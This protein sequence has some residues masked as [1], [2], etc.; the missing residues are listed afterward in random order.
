MTALAGH[1]TKEFAETV[2]KAVEEQFDM[3]GYVQAHEALAA[4]NEVQ[5]YDSGDE[6]L[7]DD[8][9]ADEKLVIPSAIRSAVFRMHV[10]TGHRSPARLARALLI[11]GAPKE[12]VIAA[13]T[14]KCSICDERKVPKT[15]R[16]ASLPTPQQVGKQLHIDLLVI[17]DAM[18]KGYI[19]AHVTDAV[20]RFQFAALLSD[21]SSK[22]VIHF[23]KVHVFSVL[24]VP[25]VMIADQGREFVS[26][27]FADFADLNNIYVK[28]IGVQAPWQ[29]GVA[30][31]S[32]GTLKALA[33]A[34]V[35]QHVVLDE[36]GMREAVA[37]AVAAYNSDINEDGTSP[38]QAV[39]GRQCLPPGD[40]LSSLSTRLAEH[41]LI[42]SNPSLARQVAMRETA[43]LSMVKLHYSK[44]LRRAALARARRVDV[45]AE[46]VPGD[47]VYFWRKIKVNSRKDKGDP[48]AAVG[49]RRGVE[50][51]RWHGPGLAVAIEGPNVFISYRGTLTKCAL[52]MTR[53][54]SSLEHLAAED[55]QEAIKELIV[56]SANP[57]D[58]EDLQPGAA[59]D[60]DGGEPGDFPP[61]DGPDVVGGVDAPMAAPVVPVSP[62]EIV[63]ALHPSS[64]LT[65][66]APSTL[67]SRQ[68]SVQSVVENRAAPG[69]PVGHLLSRVP[70]TGVIGSRGY[71][72]SLTR[73][74][75]IDEESETRGV[76]RAASGDVEELREGRPALAS[77]TSS[78]SGLRPDGLAAGMHGQQ[79]IHAEFSSLPGAS[80]PSA[81]PVGQ[82][83]I[84][85][86]PSSLPGSSPTT[87]ALPAFEALTLSA[88]ELD[89]LSYMRDA[90]HPLLQVQAQAE[91]DRRFPM[92]AWSTSLGRGMDD[93]LFYVNENG[94][95]G[96]SWATPCLT[97]WS[98]MSMRSRLPGRSTATSRW[99][100]L[101]R[102]CTMRRRLLVGRPTS[103]TM[104]S[105]SL[106]G[107]P[108]KRYVVSSLPEERWTA[109]FALVSL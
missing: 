92:I 37:E 41:S 91:L 68:E 64:T 63:A 38:L 21:K 65:T 97:G 23:L 51:R 2:V 28:H 52:E 71:Q 108:L 17:E 54:A 58:G 77:S 4:E 45:A 29:N 1:Y 94:T 12:A 95:F 86:E 105:R 82:Q 57:G 101:R 43:R 67:P 36:S 50:L 100:R 34:I 62:D 47:L 32:G 102:P 42:E 6:L 75:S 49:R 80:P 16:P 60:D 87:A 22:S 35:A 31:R 90:T 5:P 72:Q 89:A 66:P 9:E 10:N 76:K 44:G 20:S 40:A 79:E 53:K 103:T 83:E 24:G 74:R 15:R 106:T 88:E 96:S 70:R 98:T 19:V 8:D 26:Q 85:A 33:S 25:K 99:T 81:G 11:S 18:R 14:L 69:T 84:P 48:N 30:E 107:R 78:A 7:Y 61:D 39:T 55:W 46:P 104:P 73:A 56:E 3:D 93:G 27:E 109:S 59:D 13:K